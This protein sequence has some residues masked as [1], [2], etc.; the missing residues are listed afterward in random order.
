MKR[1]LRWLAGLVALALVVAAGFA[2]LQVR[3]FNASMAKVYDVP[4]PA[5][6][7]STEPA[8]LARGKHVAESL[9]GCAAG[10]CHGADLAGGRSVP[11]GPIGTVTGPNITFAGHGGAYSDGELARLILHGIKRDGRS[12]LFMPATDFN[13]LPDEDVR[14]VISYVR[15]VPAVD[16]PDGP[17]QIG[18]FGKV[19]DRQDLLPLDIARRIDHAHRTVAPAPAE[20]AA[21]GAFVGRLCVGCHGEHLSG[22]P[23][24]GA[25][26]S[27][28]I[29][30]NITTHAT[31]IKG[32]TFA[33]FDRLLTQGV[34][35]NGT[36]INPF[37][38]IEAFGKMNEVEK[39][40]LWAFLESVPPQP[41]G[42]R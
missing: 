25:P 8:V 1:I 26:S 2:A 21:Y 31:G 39:K 40:A 32:W 36:K 27:I 10:D 16:K 12:L 5:V 4:L 15:S 11:F 38:P 37:M 9:A 34:K 35:K 41:F 7:R 24:P 28:P 17:N 13:W 23:I 30:A 18:V 22:G 14:A 20:T 19:L 6:D 3:A 33:D 29:P 42:S